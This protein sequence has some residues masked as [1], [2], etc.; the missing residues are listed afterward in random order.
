[1]HPLLGINEFEIK[2]RREL[3]GHKHHYDVCDAKNGKVLMAGEERELGTLM[4]VWRITLGMI[5]QFEFPPETWV[6]V[7]ALSWG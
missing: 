3:L 7:L 4:Q 6:T 5:P 1:M 2:M